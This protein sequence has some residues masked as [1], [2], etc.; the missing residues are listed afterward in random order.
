[1]SF[2]AGA[3][4]AGLRSQTGLGALKK[5][6]RSQVTSSHFQFEASVDLDSHF[7]KSEAN[8]HRW[9]YGIGLTLQTGE[10]LAIWIEPHPASSGSE[11]DKVIKKFQWLIGKLNQN[12]FEQLKAQTELAQRQLNHPF[13]WVYSGN[14]S[15]R[16]GGKEAKKLAS[17]GLKLPE[18]TVKLP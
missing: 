14:C 6:Y 15:Y 12:T 11:V 5:E 18:R 2:S 8:L 3:A 9:D 17:V 10:T 13:R 16:A 1:M 4:H 7:K